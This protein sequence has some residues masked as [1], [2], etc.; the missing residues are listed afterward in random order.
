[1]T[2][3]VVPM[4]CFACLWQSDI[5][6]KEEQAAMPQHSFRRVFSGL[7]GFVTL[8]LTGLTLLSACGFERNVC[9]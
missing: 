4:M 5:L 9:L 1:M 2:N 6:W 7:G 8:E 3:G